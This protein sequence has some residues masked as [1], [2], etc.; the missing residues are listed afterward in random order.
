MTESEEQLHTNWQRRGVTIHEP[1]DVHPS[2]YLAPGVVVWPFTTICAGVQIG[3][4]T[5]IGAR[6]YV[7]R[8]T[9]V[10]SECR[11][12]DGSHLTDRMTVGNRV[13][14]G[15]GVLTSN[16][17]HPRVMNPDYV[18]D[19]PIIEDGVSVGSGANLLPGVRL[20]RGSMIAAGAVVH[21]DVL[22]GIV[23]AGNPARPLPCRA[24]D[25]PHRLD[26]THAPT[27]MMD[28]AS[29]GTQPS[30]RGPHAMHQTGCATGH[31]EGLSR[32]DVA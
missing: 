1:A 21:K 16:D 26:A 13:F 17:R 6:V 31:P 24:C 5:V 7:G 4:D 12:N 8:E 18:V 29:G 11:V 22:P 14:F 2:A 32:K 10:G 15:P 9:V 28:L 20:G 25:Q 3:R 19:P 30:D 27:E 23:V